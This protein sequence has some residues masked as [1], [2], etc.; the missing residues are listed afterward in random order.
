MIGIINKIT[1]EKLMKMISSGQQKSS[2]KVDL[3][4]L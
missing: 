4:V 3:N 1:R 2:L